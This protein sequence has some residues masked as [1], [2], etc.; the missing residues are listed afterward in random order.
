LALCLTAPAYAADHADGPAAI[1]KNGTAIDLSADIT[2]VYAWSDT[3]NV[4]LIMNVGANSTTSSKFSDKVQYVFHVNAGT[5]YGDTTPHAYTIVCTFTTDSPQITKC[6]LQDGSTTSDYVKGDA[7]TSAGA[8][9]ASGKLKVFSALRDDAFFFN[10]QGFRAVAKLVH[11]NVGAG[12][13][14]E[15]TLDP[16]G[17]PH[18]DNLGAGTAASVRTALTKQSDG[19]T[20][21]VDDFRKGGSAASPL[22]VTALSGN[23]LSI[24]VQVDKKLVTNNG[25]NPVIGVWASTH[26]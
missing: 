3:S 13:H 14:I 6:W 1:Q 10:I 7:T 25:S 8:M 23:I 9:S 5:K 16:A 15:T 12:L 2:D 21:G 17:C 26:K 20:A 18:L 24:A 11:D 19:T 4:Y 22:G